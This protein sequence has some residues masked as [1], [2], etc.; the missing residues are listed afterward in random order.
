MGWVEGRLHTGSREEQLHMGWE[1]GPWAR[2]AGSQ[3]AGPGETVPG[4]TCWAEPDHSEV[5]YTEMAPSR[6]PVALA[7]GD[8]RLGAEAGHTH[9]RRWTGGE[10]DPVVSPE[11]GQPKAK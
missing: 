8:L 3:E 10:A 11:G 6:L 7:A 5:H 2:E 9:S 4:R 1:V